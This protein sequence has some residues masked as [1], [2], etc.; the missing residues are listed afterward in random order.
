MLTNAK[1]EYDPLPPLLFTLR[2]SQLTY[3]TEMENA[4]WNESE[5][6]GRDITDTGNDT[7]QIFDSNNEDKFDP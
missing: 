3:Y 5:D 4:A 6:E 2:S 1:A 7:D